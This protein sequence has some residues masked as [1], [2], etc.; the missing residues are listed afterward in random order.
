LEQGE[1]NTK[2]LQQRITELTTENERLSKKNEDLTNNHKMLLAELKSAQQALEGLK[3]EK[4][5][6]Q[7]SHKYF[8]FNLFDFFCEILYYIVGDEY[9]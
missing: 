3:E 8:F 9:I 1:D 7:I 6:P 5:S 4:R 2:E